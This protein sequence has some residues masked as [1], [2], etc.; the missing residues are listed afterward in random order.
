MRA[1]RKPVKSGADFI[2]GDGWKPLIVTRKGAERLA[3][4]R[5]PDPRF[6]TPV[7]SDAGTH[8]RVS[9]G[10]QPERGW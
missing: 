4:R 8:W 1:E 6:F 7:V 2:R 3:R 9:Y 10:G 5:N